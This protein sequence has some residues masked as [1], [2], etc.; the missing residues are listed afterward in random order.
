MANQDVVLDIA[1]DRPTVDQIRATG[2]V[3]VVRYFSAD[4]TKNWTLQEFRDYTAAGLMVASVW[5]TTAGRALADYTAGQADARAADAQRAADGFPAD[6]PIHFAVDTDTDW[7]HVA[8]YF[9]GVANVLT[10]DRVGVYGGLQVIEGAA[11]AGYPFRWQTAAWSG[12]QV[13]PHATLYQA[14][15]A[16][17]GQ[18]DTNHV[19]AQDWGQYP[20]PEVDMPLTPDDINA[21]WAHPLVDAMDNKPR[22]ASAY[23]AWMDKIH[24]GQSDQINAVKADVD[25]LKAALPAGALQ[26]TDAQLQALAQ[27]VAPAVAQAVAP[28]LVP[29][30]LAAMGHALDG[31]TPPA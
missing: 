26:L 3:G 24:Q 6:M 23:L 10:R 11:A 16:L 19:M 21:I 25:A 9:A 5:E 1:W 22:P 20:R 8:P 17:G 12:G 27:A 14:G 7:A 30:L 13:S 18:A 29:A 31:S 2:A 4:V 15:T 28:V